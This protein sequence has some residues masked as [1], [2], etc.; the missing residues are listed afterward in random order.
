MVLKVLLLLK[1]SKKLINLNILFSFSMK[2]IFDFI[3]AF[4]LILIFIFPFLLLSLLI[5]FTSSGTILYCSIRVGQ[6]NSLFN[7]PKF[8]TMR[9][10]TPVVASH[11]LFNSDNYLTLLGSFLRKTSID[12]LPQLWCI[13]IGRM[14]FVGPRPALYNQDDLIE[15][16]TKYGVHYLKPG[17]TG[18]AQINGRDDLSINDK[19]KFD[20]EYLNRQSF[21]FDLKIIALTIFK[22][23]FR[24]GISH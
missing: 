22:V 18:W 23:L 9:V 13:L 10:D 17:L 5:K 15:L 7:M 6:D 11:L 14:S 3:F 8:R 4:F 20:L 24:S 16:R 19:V 21:L 12:E 2:R 1:K